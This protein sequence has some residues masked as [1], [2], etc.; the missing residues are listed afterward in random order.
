MGFMGWGLDLGM[1]GREF[2]LLFLP[3]FGLKA[4]EQ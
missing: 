1:M 4:V 2:D 3:A